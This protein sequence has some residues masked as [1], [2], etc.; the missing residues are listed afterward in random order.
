[1]LSYEK[2]S[3]LI[4]QPTGP[5]IPRTSAAITLFEAILPKL[6]ATSTVSSD[7]ARKVEKRYTPTELQEALERTR[8]DS[9]QLFFDSCVPIGK[10]SR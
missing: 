3:I 10:R 5:G 2:P 7:P 9:N 4:C 8:A 6:S 1:M